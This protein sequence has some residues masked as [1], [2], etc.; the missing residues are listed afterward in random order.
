M[1][2]LA[3]MGI[4][5]LNAMQCAVADVDARVRR[6][7]LTAPTGSGKT[8]A[9]AIALLRGMRPAVPGRAPGA[10]VLAPSRELAQQIYDVIRPLAAPE[11]KTVVVCGGR[12]AESEVPSLTSAT[13]PDIVI[14]TP[15]RLL[16]H[17]ARGTIVPRNIRRVVI[18]EYDKLLALGFER[19]TEDIMRRIGS[20]PDLLMLTSATELP[21]LPSFI[22]DGD[23]PKV[24]KA[25][26][27]MGRKHSRLTVMDVV[28]PE[29]DKLDS[30]AV[31]VRELLAAGQTAMVFVNHRDAAERVVSGLG[32]RGITAVLYHGGLEQR[33]REIAVAAFASHAADVMVSTDLGARG[34][35]IPDVGA[36]IH[37]HLPVDE[38]A[39]THRNGRT[40]R[41][42]ADG[43]AYVILG[44][45]ESL[46]AY[47]D[48]DHTHYPAEPGDDA[49]IREPYTL[50]YIDGGRRRKISRGDI[51]GFATKNAGIPG[52]K[53]GHITIAPDYALVAVAAEYAQAL[54]QA[55][56]AHRLKGQKVRI[57]PV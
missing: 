40:A 55:A 47:I 49:A 6:L 15:G 48:T 54:C 28:S 35:D 45:T 11:L 21:S 26:E 8:V 34:L 44:P 33:Q 53:V 18:D 17:I 5:R 23:A 16:D 51:L 2:K 30:L 42:G 20:C 41:A 24:I 52:D 31:L 39:Y 3:R 43:L 27:D 46:P 32:R 57:T 37:Y 4:T 12:S 10:L 7:L 50:M 56:R 29:R 38:A 19:Q 9:Y 1:F 25:N 36:V 22:A 13:P 14:A